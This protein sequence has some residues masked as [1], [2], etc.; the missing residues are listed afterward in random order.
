M[1]TASANTSAIPKKGRG[2]KLSSS[3]PKNNKN[4]NKNKTKA[5]S[6]KTTED[7]KQNDHNKN[8]K[9][10]VKASTNTKK[11]TKIKTLKEN[12]NQS[13]QKISASSS[14]AMPSTNSTSTTSKKKETKNNKVTRDPRY[15]T[16][17]VVLPKGARTN[18][19]TV[20]K[21]NKKN[22]VKVP[23]VPAV[24]IQKFTSLGQEGVF[25]MIS[26]DVFPRFQKTKHYKK[27]TDVFKYLNNTSRSGKKYYNK[28]LA[29]S[30]GEFS[31]ESLEFYMLCLSIDKAKT[32]DAQ[33]ALLEDAWHKYGKND[34]PTPI[35]ISA[36]DRTKLEG[37][38]NFCKRWGD[39]FDM[40]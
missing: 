7:P 2:A 19:K 9:N 40:L 22:K 28:F 3:V 25:G 35:N 34:G 6:T 12:K 18:P 37:V 36:C 31:N 39:D 16:S 20:N 27:G 13:V 23:V 1:S 24:E 15:D 11:T 4:K 38:Y 8:E 30:V 33:M 10:I 14:T 29:F 17:V 5:L 21:K 32:Y 26:N